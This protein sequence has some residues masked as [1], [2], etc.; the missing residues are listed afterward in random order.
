M[1]FVS[2]LRRRGSRFAGGEGGAVTVEFVLWMPF[3]L[4]LFT[5][6]L[7]FAHSFTVNSTMWHQT[8][9][10]ARGLSMHTLTPAQAEQV[11]RDGLAWIDATP[12]IDILQTRD[13]VTIEVRVPFDR[14]GV[15]NIANGGMTGDWVT[16]VT[17]LREPV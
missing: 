6:F 7:D 4:V 1:S 8:R 15:V 16:R 3:V 11:V 12:G 2:A 13:T 10:A 5:G 17:M 9:V 14:S